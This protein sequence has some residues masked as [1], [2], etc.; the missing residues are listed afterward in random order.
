MPE[1]VSGEPSPRLALRDHV[2]ESLGELVAA[3]AFLTRVP[4]PMRI[5]GQERTGAAAFGLVGLFLGASAAV[6]IGLVGGGHPVV[7]AVAGLA[8]LQVLAG[9][10]HLDGLADTA[11]ALAA[12]AGRADPART[13]PRA[14]TAGVT[15]IAVVLGLDAAVVA[16]LAARDV[17]LAGCTIVAAVVASRATAPLWAIVVGRGRS[18]RHGLAA[19]FAEATSVGEA[20][21]SATTLLVVELMLVEV[22]GPRVLIATATGLGAAAIVGA[23]IVGL[24]HQL[25]GDGYGAIIEVTV[26]A[27]L[28]ASV[29]IG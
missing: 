26:A 20:A 19:W 7:A 5:G 9:A 8:I 28:V 10:F 18:P 22:V 2:R 14:G 13:D 11:D 16:E 4:V 24:R 17:I 12:P 27:V 6:P 15:A 23:G 3:I 21:V 25:D 1:V 29:L